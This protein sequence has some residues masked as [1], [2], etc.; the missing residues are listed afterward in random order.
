MSDIPA[1]W[2]A[3]LC[4]KNKILA[5]VCHRSVQQNTFSK[6]ALG[7][8]SKVSPPYT[9]RVEYEE[10]AKEEREYRQY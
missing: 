8:R 6:I 7:V 3:T 9:N 2:Y 10:C 4:K 1:L 5:E